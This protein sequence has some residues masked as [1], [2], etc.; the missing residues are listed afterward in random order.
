MRQ[1]LVGRVQLQKG[2]S[3][4][5]RGRRKGAPQHD[6]EG[7][8]DITALERTGTRGQKD[9]GAKGEEEAQETPV[10]QKRQAMEIP[11]QRAKPSDR[12]RQAQRSK[13]RGTSRS[14]KESK[15]PLCTFRHG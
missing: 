8:T 15:D 13:I 3:E 1:R 7:H 4:R 6:L 14:R 9:Q 5:A 2:E 10:G 12:D 11:R